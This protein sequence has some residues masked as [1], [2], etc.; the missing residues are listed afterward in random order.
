MTYLSYEIQRDGTSQI[1]R[2]AEV[3]LPAY[4]KIEERSTEDF[5]ELLYKLAQHIVYHDNTNKSFGNWQDFLT[6]FADK[7]KISGKLSEW[8]KSGNAKPHQALIIAFLK[9]LEY[10]NIDLNKLSGKH[11]D[12]FYNKVLR[13]EKNDAVADKVHV[14]FE[15]AK[16]SKYVKLPAGT[17]LDAGKDSNKNPKYY[18]LVNEKVINQSVISSLRSVYLDKSDKY[19]LYSASVANSSDGK[20]TAFADENTA[21]K[22]F[23]E[24]QTGLTDDELTMSDAQVGFAIASP[25]LNLSA[26]ERTIKVDVT[27]RTTLGK[28][29]KNLQNDFKIYLTGEKGWMECE[30][31]DGDLKTTEPK[32]SEGPETTDSETSTYNTSILSFEVKLNSDAKASASYSSDLHTGGFKSDWPI[33]KVLLNPE[34]TSYPYQKLSKLEV[35]KVDLT[36]EVDGF[37]DFKLKN[38]QGFIDPSKPFLPFG[39]TPRPG[40][41]F[42]IVSTE[43]TSKNIDELTLSLKWDNLPQDSLG[44]YYSGYATNI[45]N[46][47]FKAIISVCKDGQFS[48]LASKQNLFDSIYA[49]AKN[50]I[51]IASGFITDV[52]DIIQSETSTGNQVRLELAKLTSTDGNDITGIKAF[53]HQ[54]Y[55]ALYADAA[56]KKALSDTVTEFNGV[57]FPNEPYTPLLKEFS[58]GYES[59][60]TISLDELSPTGQVFNIGPFGYHEVDSDSNYYSLV[61]V[62]EDEGNF[63]IGIKSLSPPQNVSILFQLA[64]GSG[65]ISSADTEPVITWS[66]LAKTGWVQLTSLE[67]VNDTTLNLQKS[68]IIEFSVGSD[69]VMG[70]TRFVDA[71]SYYWIKGSVKSNPD[72]L[73][74]LI[75]L[76]ANAAIAEYDLES[77]KTIEITTLAA[78]TIT[79]LVSKNASIKK[80]SQPYA[81]FGGREAEGSSSYYTRVSERLRHKNREI[82]RWDFERNILEEFPD[83]YKVKCLKHADA[84]S[85]IAPGNVT[86]LIISNLRNTNAPNPLEP[87]TSY[88]TL[89]EIKTFAEKYISPFVTLN[90]ENPTYEQL[91][92]D[93]KV[94]FYEG[95]DGGYYGNLLNLEI[96]KFLSPWAYDEGKDIVFG[97]K[98][99]R[100]D[101][102]WFVENLPYVD[103]VTEFKLYH[104]YAS[105]SK[106]G[107]DYMQV[108]NDFIVRDYTGKGIEEMEIGSTFIVGYESEVAEASSPRS[109]LV[110]A[111][112]HRIEVLKTGEYTCTGNIYDGIGKMA[113]E[114]NFDV[115]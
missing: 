25:L 111:R 89:T 20:G 40:S 11:L 21:W 54:E 85:D 52:S 84:T 36:T 81:S 17:L 115:E 9:L 60:D 2:M 29:T 69:A 24:T 37:T 95:Y 64:E 13:I 61:P 27:C 56:I 101:I 77:A 109:I 99:Y 88:G 32:S 1:K 18:K 65:T 103:Y 80:I 93:F 113:I 31:V 48:S 8:E 4:A 49:S 57:N 15:L 16:N 67:I 50:D 44:N 28:S 47:S 79:K 86:L 45:N 3:L 43:L 30:W 92:V 19:K 7:T 58:I 55:T 98:V 114:I 38:E 105:P 5:L 23:G 46:E 33:L 14:I 59:S 83:V 76:Y 110:S 34:S 26:G 97:G 71:T 94:G 6:E 63:Y 42:D 96:K 87:T 72:Q 70:D 53:G 10:A 51:K 100:S 62:I 102:L 112:K 82:T 68:G 104:I 75:K 12:F 39:P 73:C 66:Y 74:K 78:K 41:Y 91:L 22:A 107:I 35:L 108:E 106:T 90:V